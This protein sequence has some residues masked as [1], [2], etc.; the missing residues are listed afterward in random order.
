MALVE[1]TKAIGEMVALQMKDK[2]DTIN[3]CEHNKLEVP[4]KLFFENMLQQCEKNVGCMSKILSLPIK[5]AKLFS[6]ME[7]S[8][9]TLAIIS[10][11]ICKS[12]NVANHAPQSIEEKLTTMNDNITIEVVMKNVN[13]NSR[14][15]L[16]DYTMDKDLT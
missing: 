13:V 16:H 4:V 8:T 7:S 6:N 5:L 15:D 9:Q 2:V 11:F 14:G 12:L 10:S 1:V 3:E